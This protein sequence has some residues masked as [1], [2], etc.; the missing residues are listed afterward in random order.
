V[1]L[2]QERRS[3]KIAVLAIF[4][5]WQYEAT[6]IV[7]EDALQI[8]GDAHSQSLFLRKPEVEWLESRAK[9]SIF[10]SICR[11]LEGEETLVG[12]ASFED[13]DDGFEAS[14]KRTW[15]NLVAL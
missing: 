4:E 12:C 10:Q 6:R 2:K 1:G 13:V 7:A 9:I 14:E 11:G 8:F 5:C 15:P 3:S